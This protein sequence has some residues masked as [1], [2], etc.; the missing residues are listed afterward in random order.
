M[1]DFIETGSEFT[2]KFLSSDESLIFNAQN[3]K[4][5][6]IHLINKALNE[7][8]K[9]IINRLILDNW[10][11]YYY[12]YRVTDLNSVTSPL[13]FNSYGFS[14]ILSSLNED[15]YVKINLY[16]T[17]QDGISNL[18]S[19][20]SIDKRSLCTDT[21]Y[22]FKL[23][24]IM[25]NL[26]DID[27]ISLDGKPNGE[28]FEGIIYPELA[29]TQNIDID[30][31]GSRNY[32]IFRFNISNPNVSGKT[33]LVARKILFKDILPVGTLFKEVLLN[34]EKCDEECVSLDGR[35]L[36]VKLPI[37]K[38]GES[39]E[40]SVVCLIDKFSGEGLNTGALV[41]V[42]NNLFNE[43]E[44]SLTTKIYTLLSNSLSL[45]DMI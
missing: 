13:E 22:G 34:G 15:R 1:N 21:P 36:F 39:I 4:K 11:D 20:R 9:G 6:I 12:D 3:N 28:N 43:K 29:I 40:L 8:P 18:L 26:L 32:V 38:E 41:Y 31:D 45:G 14:F 5:Y 19:P 27:Q 37:I 35:R 10:G 2:S 17:P 24:Q 7:N 30:H 44:N 16:K 42:F 25:N 33:V 23:S